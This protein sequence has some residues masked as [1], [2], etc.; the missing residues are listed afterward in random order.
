M[1]KRT[2][3]DWFVFLTLA[4]MW[5][6][7]FAFTKVAV[8]GLPPGLIVTC[9]LAL[10][11]LLMC[12]V[13]A[14]S[15]HK[16]PPF[17]DRHAWKAMIAM[18]IIGTAAP[19]YLITQG[20]R[21]IDSA[22]AALLI[23]S[24]PLF[25]AAMAHLRFEDE[26][27]T[28]NKVLGI[29]VGFIGVAVL[30]GPDAVGGIGSA[31]MVA[32]FLCLGA[33]FCYAVNTIIARSA[34]NLPAIV[35]PTGFLAAATLAS[36]PAA[37]LDDYAAFAPNVSNALAVVALGAVPTAAAGVLLMRLIQTTSATFVSLT[38]YLI[39]LISAVI[40]YLAFGETQDVSA[41]LAFA[42]ILGGVWLSQRQPRSIQ[43]PKATSDLVD[44]VP[45]TESER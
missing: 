45:F 41:V 4:T 31:D 30:L 6:S 23:A 18:G 43:P 24:A 2:P 44:T 8:E 14:F 25:V 15:G 3:L 19:F 13:M 34:P 17:S 10:G 28:V 12:T 7:A 20:Q 11:A 5:A 40:G 21:T 36:I 32:Q 39:P 22:L 29:L 16:L 26:R 37:L 38:G 9:R 1:T 33:G 27:L 35:L 42:L